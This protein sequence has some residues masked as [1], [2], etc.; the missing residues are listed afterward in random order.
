MGGDAKSD[1]GPALLAIH[2]TWHSGSQLETCSP[3]D[4]P[5][6]LLRCQARVEPWT[7]LNIESLKG[8]LP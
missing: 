5:P 7:I 8:Q 1:H 2:A 4:V 3:S 6:E